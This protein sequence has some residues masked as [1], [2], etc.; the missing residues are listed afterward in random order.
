MTRPRALFIA[1]AAPARSGNGLAMRLGIFLEALS[2]IADTE[3]LVL[4]I[5]GRGAEECEL[6]RELGLPAT[7]VAVAGRADTNYTLLKQ[8]A[9]HTERLVAFKIYG[10][11]S[12]HAAVSL[13][14]VEA[15]R[16]V[17][18]H[19]GFDL[20]HAGRLYT[21]EAG[22][23]VGARHRTIDL[24]E[25]DAWAWRRE[26]ELARAA[27]NSEAADWAEA[28][29]EAED[30]L[31][32]RIASSFDRMFIAGE[33]DRERLRSRHRDLTV[34]VV[35]NGVSLAPSPKRRDDGDT[36]LFVGNLTYAPN[37][38]GL[39]WFV[40]EVLPL[41]L[42]VRDVRLRIVGKG[43]S[44]TVEGLRG[45]GGI[46]VVGAV[47]DVAPAYETATLA[48]APLHSGAGTRIKL[49]E[50]AAFNVPMVSTSIAAQGLDFGPDAIWRA[51]S[52]GAFADA[53][54]TALSNPD[55]RL[56]R[57]ERARCIAGLQYDR[58][59]LIASLASR[60]GE[61]LCATPTAGLATSAGA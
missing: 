28:E 44:P 59:K 6:T 56:R 54:L 42:E 48:I 45:H 9:S 21:A 14:V 7:T 50:A 27:G 30:R 19:R 13:P 24:D 38:E 31:L 17:A 37:V 61:I 51:D 5:A 58:E 35:P 39:L 15:V 10:R 3:L 11:G 25:D 43:Q 23:A 47:E 34:E 2:R 46:E 1:P 40:R 26:A 60:F 55:E 57:A 41:I 8:L 52:P 36:L 29:A 18:A 49:I 22:L 33:A 32:G 4:P 12:R 53:V 16:S 20:V